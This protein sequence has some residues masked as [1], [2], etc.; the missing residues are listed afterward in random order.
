MKAR[1]RLDVL[2]VARGLAESRSRAAALVMAGRVLV[3]D[4]PVTKPGTKIPEDA[5]VRVRGGGHD[6]VSRGGVKLD[7]A[8]SAFAAG[9]LRVEGRVALD[10]GASTGGFTECLLRR[11]AAKV[12]AVDV[13]YGQL[14]P[15]LARDRRVVV[16]D[17]TN[18]R[19][20]PDDLLGEP[21]GLVVVDCSF[22]ALAKVLPHLPR[23]LAPAADVVALVKPQFELDPGR[24]GKGGVVRDDADRAAAVA[25]ADRAAAALG[26]ERRGQVDA[27]IA[28]RAGN[29]EIFVWWAAGDRA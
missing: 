5:A 20:A 18:I 1:Q 13:G 4:R 24:V 22:I 26:L 17:R 28:G 19:T 16:H 25:R 12:H 6:F 11:G 21:V 10:V 27:P 7:G 8:L 9:G 14:H 23:F 2:L 3:D 15:K 29:R